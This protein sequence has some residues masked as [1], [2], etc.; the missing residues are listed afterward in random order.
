V[1]TW[2]LLLVEGPLA[3][4]SLQPHDDLALDDELESAR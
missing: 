1:L 4:R 2:T 3:W